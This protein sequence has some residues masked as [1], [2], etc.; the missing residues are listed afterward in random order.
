MS[1]YQQQRE[2]IKKSILDTSVSLF[3]EKGYENTT[4]DEITKAVGIAKGTFYNFYSSK[5]EILLVWAAE[6]FKTINMSEAFNATKT[7][8]D[9]LHK[10]IEI[11]V[12]GI[13]NEEQLFKCFLKELLKDYED[14][15]YFEKFDFIS[16]FKLI[17]SNSSDSD[18]VH[19]D[20]IDIK[21][22]VLNNSLFMAILNWFDAGKSIKELDKY[23]MKIITVCL[24]GILGDVKGKDV[25]RL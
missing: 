25:N 24:Y 11:I 10:F 7:L 1:L 18:K 17:I 22:H 12:E 8:E 15:S 21:I 13:E 9:N 16:I 2:H 3:L 19:D 14:K 5:S 20:M 4:I 23:L 6:K